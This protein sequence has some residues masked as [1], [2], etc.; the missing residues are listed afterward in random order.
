MTNLRQANDQQLEA[1]RFTASQ[2]AREQSSETLKAAALERAGELAMEG[3][4]MESRRVLALNFF[5]E[6]E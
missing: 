4:L 2:A 3:R 1:Q 5:N 6:S